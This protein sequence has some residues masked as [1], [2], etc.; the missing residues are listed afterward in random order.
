MK[1]LRL[2]AVLLRVVLGAAVPLG[3]SLVMGDNVALLTAPLTAGVCNVVILP[4]VLSRML[5]SVAALDLLTEA[6]LMTFAIEISRV[7]SLFTKELVLSAAN[8]I[9][10]AVET[11]VVDL[12][13]AP[14][15]LMR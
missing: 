4:L 11:L 9:L 5:L 13:I 10:L 3:L 1:L 8:V 15:V 6:S 2:T 14:G 12:S 7:L